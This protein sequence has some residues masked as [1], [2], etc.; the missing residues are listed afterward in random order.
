MRHSVIV[1]V[2][3]MYT[4]TAAKVTAAKRQ[5]N[6]ASRIAA[7]RPNSSSTGMIENSM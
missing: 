5:S 2:N 1:T 6:L 7:T 3:A 4:A